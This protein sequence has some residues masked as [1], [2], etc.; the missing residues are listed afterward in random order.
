MKHVFCI[1]EEL[2]DF[3]RN[4]NSRYVIH[5]FPTGVLILVL[6]ITSSVKE[7][8]TMIPLNNDIK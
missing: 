1:E 2:E 4:L 3:H 7:E 8:H 5:H 6:D